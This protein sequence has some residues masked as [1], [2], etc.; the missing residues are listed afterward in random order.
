MQLTLAL[1]TTLLPAL[2]FSQFD[3]VGDFQNGFDSFT[4]TGL[5]ADQ[6]SAL[7]SFSASV[8]SDTKAQGE[9]YTAAFTGMTALP[10]GTLD[11]GDISSGLQAA[12][13]GGKAA[14]IKFPKDYP[15]PITSYI[16]SIY[17]DEASVLRKYASKTGNYAPAMT[18][19]LAAAGAVAAGVVG[20]AVL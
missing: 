18:G 14:D 12:V 10:T 2:A 19:R 5:N 1:L 8:V 9:V 11:E 17:Q 4:L 13:T 20:V 6:S 7:S 16:N 3:G 15:A